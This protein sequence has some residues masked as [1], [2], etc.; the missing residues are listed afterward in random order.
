MNRYRLLDAPHKGLR[1]LLGQWALVS[2]NCD[3]R[4]PEDL[5]RLKS[6]T[7][8]V[9]TMLEDHAANEERWVFPLAEARMPGATSALHADHENLDALLVSVTGKI[10]RLSADSTPEVLSDMHLAVTQFQGCYLIHLVEEERDF[11]PLLWELYTDEELQAA[12]AEVAQSLNPALL[13]DWFAI[14]APARTDAENLEVLRNVHTVLPKEAFDAILA[15][16]SE[17]LPPSRYATIVEE[18]F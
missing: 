12:E 18:L 6:L 5:E 3:P 7:A 15:R 4:V 2:G 8:H 17:V 16:L 1:N 9:V 11:E 13:L 10:E 14:C